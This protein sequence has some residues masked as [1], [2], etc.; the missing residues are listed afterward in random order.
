[1]L[2]RRS[3]RSYDPDVVEPADAHGPDLLAGLEEA[4]PWDL[5]LSRDPEQGRLLDDAALDAALE[6]V[7]DFVDLKSPYLPGH[8]R[9]VAALAEASARELGL[10]QADATALRRAGMVHDLGRCAISNA[11]WDKESALTRDE[12]DL[13]ETHPLRSE[14]IVRRVPG[15]GVCMTAVGHHHERADGAGYH[16]GVR[17]GD[18]P[19][20][21]RVLAAADTFQALVEPRAHRPAR[22]ADQAAAE[23]RTAARTGHL[24]PAAADA[25]PR[26][27]RGP[28]PATGRAA[29]R[30]D[31]PGGRGARAVGSRLHDPAGRGP[32]RDQP[33]DRR[34]SHPAHLPEDR[35]LD[36]RCGGTVRGAARAAPGGTWL[37]CRC[38]LAPRRAACSAPSGPLCAERPAPRQ[39]ARSASSGLLRAN[40]CNAGDLRPGRGRPGPS[41]RE[42]QH[43]M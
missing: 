32:P 8:S 16:R 38:R 2:R 22:P 4:D 5:T 25:S 1:V 34:R 41:V 30:P 18:L 13:V 24:D 27:R 10:P 35:G 36:P 17:I 6:V 23:L 11:V 31:S 15:L 42:L 7:A 21:A 26:R 20:S 14:Q 33:Q 40:R 19:L 28:A 37:T 29:G 9:G 43:E 3:G 12:R 39:P